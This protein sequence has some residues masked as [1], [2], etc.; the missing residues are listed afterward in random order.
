MPPNPTRR[1]HP[2]QPPTHPP[3]PNAGG[4]A[5]PSYPPKLPTQRGRACPNSAILPTDRNWN[6][7][8][9][10]I[11]RAAGR[12][13]G[14]GTTRSEGLLASASCFSPIQAASTVTTI[15]NRGKATSQPKIHADQ[16]TRQP[17]G[18]TDTPRLTMAASHRPRCPTP[19]M[20]QPHLHD[21]Q[22][23]N[24]SAVRSPSPCLLPIHRAG[25][26]V[27]HE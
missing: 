6:L 20:P 21:L 26:V 15:K 4:P 17:S 9:T 22:W 7:A 11:N 14:R 23:T 27:S 12:P 5:Q 8:V 25:P 13:E 2:T 1:D 18:N 19:T 10:P 3:N 16:P 24:S